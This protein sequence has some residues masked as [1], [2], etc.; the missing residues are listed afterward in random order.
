MHRMFGPG[1]V[2]ATTAEDG[3]QDGVTVI[4]GGFH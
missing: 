1:S 2:S 4:D 3:R